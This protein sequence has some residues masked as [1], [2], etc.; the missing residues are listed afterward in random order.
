MGINIQPKNDCSFLFSSLGSAA[1]KVAGSNW[2]ADYASI[3]NGS[4]AKL[5]K[6]YYAET[7]SDSVKSLVQDTKTG[8]SKDDSKTLA[9]IQKSTDELKESADALLATGRES[10]FQQKDIT[11]TDEN[12]EE[13]TTRGYDTSA[14]YN[15]VSDFVKDY[16]GVLK[17]VDTAESKSIVNRASNLLAITQSN[18]KL[19]DKL[20]IT[21][22]E[23]FTLSLD[24]DKFMAADMSTAKSLFH[25]TGAYAYQVSAQSSLINFAADSEA[26]KA[27]TYANNGFYA[28]NYTSG[29]IFNSYF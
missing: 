6:A 29:N 26:S 3:K 15:A 9:A 5:M 1:S 7:S 10:L 16:N 4:Y 20:G 19:L 23:D 27:N 8:T 13:T 25:G 14:I 12:G 11:T 28:N 2:L 18:S 17:S 22:N 24:K 21:I